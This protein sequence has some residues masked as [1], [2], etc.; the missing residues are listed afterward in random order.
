MPTKFH[1]VESCMPSTSSTWPKQLKKE[2]KTKMQR[3]GAH[4]VDWTNVVHTRIPRLILVEWHKSQF[5]L[6]VES[7]AKAIMSQI[8]KCPFCMGD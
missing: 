3:G 8:V 7:L 5:K 2:R 4:N 1:F 6:I